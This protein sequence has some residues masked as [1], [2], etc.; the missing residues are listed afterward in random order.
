MLSYN[1]RSYHSDEVE[2]VH[3]YYEKLVLQEVLQQSIRVQ[4]GDREFM[5]D[6]ACVALNRLPPRYIRHDVDMTFFMSPQDMQETEQKITDAV[7]MALIYVE[8]RELGGNTEV[9]SQR[10][11]AVDVTAKTE[12][13]LTAPTI[14]EPQI[15]PEKN[16]KSPVT[17]PPEKKS[18]K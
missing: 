1:S 10:S 17:K 9:S 6:V 4:A 12:T 15:E 11:G 7:A 8:S 18:K 5:A 14:T 2:F 3:N 16:K 13:I